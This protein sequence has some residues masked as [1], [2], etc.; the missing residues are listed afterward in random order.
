M[1][2]EAM[3]PTWQNWLAQSLPMLNKLE[4]LIGNKENVVPE[5]HLVMRAFATDPKLIKVVIVGQDP[6]PTK[7]DAIGL[8][9][10]M[11]S[12][13]KKPKSL[14]NIMTELNS[15]LGLSV[16]RN[17]PDLS[18]W[19]NQGVLLLNRTLTTEEGKARAH[20]KLGW[21]EFTFLA[22]CELAKRNKLVFILWGKDASELG[23]RVAQEAGNGSVLIESPHP[24]PLSAYRGFFGSKPFSKTN[25]ELISMGL[26]PIDWSL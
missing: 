3:H 24:S 15:D 14:V 13:R 25:Q 2:F 6:Y 9:F 22:L 17:N 20:L 26:E 7:G 10:A 1:F 8:A 18:K 4:Q 5:Q 23:R 12:E 11:N 21:D 16:E 19:S